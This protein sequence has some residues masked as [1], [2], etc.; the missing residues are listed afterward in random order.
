[1]FAALMAI[2][3]KD[4]FLDNDIIIIL[5]RQKHCEGFAVLMAI[6]MKDIIVILGRQKKGGCMVVLVN[7]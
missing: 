1:M 4:I 7:G 3:M 6:L 2:L 5:G